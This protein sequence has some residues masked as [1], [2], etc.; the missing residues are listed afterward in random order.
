MADPVTTYRGTVPDRPTI[1]RECGDDVTMR[2]ARAGDVVEVPCDECRGELGCRTCT[3]DGT[4]NV[5]LTED[6][7]ARY[8]GSQL[9]CW[10][11]VGTIEP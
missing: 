9:V 2:P 4:V 1:V 6:P 5:R 7:E 8:L 3:G 10:L 11:I